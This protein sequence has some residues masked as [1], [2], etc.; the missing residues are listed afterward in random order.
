MRIPPRPGP[1]WAF[2][3]PPG[4]PPT[5]KGWEPDEGW[6]GPDPDWPEP[7]PYWNWWARDE[8]DPD[9]ATEQA[10]T[11]HSPAGSPTDASSSTVPEIWK[12][13]LVGTGALATLVA[14]AFAA[15]SESNPVEPGST[16]VSEQEARPNP[17]AT[18]VMDKKFEPATTK[19][20]IVWVDGDCVV[21]S[22]WG[23]CYQRNRRAVHQR[24]PVPERYI[25]VIQQRGKPRRLQVDAFSYERCAP[26]DEWPLCRD[27]D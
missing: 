11:S 8:A 25:L 19:T 2:N 4:W 27:Q 26:G 7:P 15:T 10:T 17:D 1:G 9:P 20:E 22:S 12:Y 13:L 16:S 18:V 3:A 14:L 21:L 6:G 5:P 24:V 23:N